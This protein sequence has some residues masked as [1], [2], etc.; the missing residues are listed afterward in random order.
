MIPLKNDNLNETIGHRHKTFYTSY[1]KL[2]G[3][4][5]GDAA[6]DG[7]ASAVDGAAVA[8]ADVDARTDDGAAVA[9]APC[10]D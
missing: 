4:P 9:P 1:V 2:W 6:A 8:A 3:G 10:D 5:R 7:V